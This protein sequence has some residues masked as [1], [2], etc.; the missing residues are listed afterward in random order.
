VPKG[1]SPQWN[2][3]KEPVLDD[4]LRESINGSGG[5]HDPVTGWYATKHIGGMANR[6]EVK[7]VIRAFHRS[8]RHLGVSVATKA[9]PNPNGGWLIEY[10]AINKAHA[11]AFVA[12]H[13]GDRPPYNPHQKRES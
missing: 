13:Y 3:R 11:R 9:I 6:D 1:P 12:Q 7:E 4:Y 2:R 5:E 10:A 8:A